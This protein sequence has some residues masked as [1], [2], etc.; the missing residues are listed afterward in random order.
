MCCNSLRGVQRARHC[1]G[2]PDHV[3]DVFGVR[4]RR[5]HHDHSSLT[6]TVA[7]AWQMCWGRLASRMASFRLS[8][9]P[10]GQASWSL[11]TRKETDT[12]HRR[13]LVLKYSVE[14]SSVTKWFVFPSQ[15]RDARRVSSGIAHCA[16][17]ECYGLPPLPVLSTRSSSS[18]A[19]NRH[20]C[21]SCQG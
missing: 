5:R 16:H 13:L 15:R 18:S 7:R 21:H 4:R 2:D 9:C 17:H 1:R 14:N 6:A 19:R 10:R 12:C 11:W 3:Q 8:A 20:I